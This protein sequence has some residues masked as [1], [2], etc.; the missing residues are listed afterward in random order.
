MGRESRNKKNRGRRFSPKPKIGRPDDYF[1]LGT[2]EIAR[3]GKTVVFRNNMSQ[4]QADSLQ[5][6][7]AE[8]F[9]EVV[10][11]IDNIISQIIRRVSS[12]P[13]GE[14]LKRGYWEMAYHHADI[15]G[16]ID[17]GHE[18]MVSLRMVDYLQG[19]IASVQP[20]N[21]GQGEIAD[22]DWR[23]L[24][25]LVDKLFIKLNTE[26]F[27]CQAAVRKFR[28]SG[29]T[30][31]YMDFY[32]KAQGYWC[33]VRGHRY[34]IHDVP[35]LREVLSPHD[36]ILREFYGLGAK[37]VVD[38]L[39]VIRDSLT[40]G[41]FTVLDDCAKFQ[42]DLD[43][44]LAKSLE[45]SSALAQFTSEDAIQ[46]IIDEKGWRERSDDIA[47]RLTGLDMFDLEKLTHLPKTL[48]DDLSWS[49]G[50]DKEFFG[51]GEY[52]G[53]PLRVWPV[54]KRPFI[55]L[56]NRY[57]CFDLYSLFDHA[58]R[59]IQRL[60]IKKRPQYSTTWKD[61]QQE[62]SERIPID[63]F[64]KL[65]PGVQ[66]HRQ[67]FYRWYTG[68]DAIKNWCETDA[69]LIHE[70][71]LIIMEVRGGA[72]TYTSPTTDFQSHI[73]SL[74]N[75]VLKP[76]E[77]GRR[78]MAYL[79]SGDSVKLYDGDHNE[80][81]TISRRKF[82]QVVIC[83][84]TLD[85]FTELAAKTQHLKKIGI[86]VGTYPIWSISIDDLWV[87][88]DIFTNPLV[89]LH[90]VKER[91]KAFTLESLEA[92]DELDHL[93]LYLKH[94]LYTRYV[95]E[96]HARAKGP[97]KWHG[98]RA[99]IDRYFSKRF[100]EPEQCGILQQELSPRVREVL[101]VLATSRKLGRR[102]LAAALLDCSGELRDTLGKEIDKELLQ[103]VSSR[104][105]KPFSSHGEA[106]ITLF[107][108]QRGIVDRDRQVAS[109]HARTVMLVANESDRLLLELFY[110]AG[111][112]IDIEHEFLS[113]DSI[114]GDELARIKHIA[115]LLRRQ[116]L[117]N[118]RLV[119]GG[120]GRNQACPCGS[121]KK[122]KKCCSL[123][124]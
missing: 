27:L 43:A 98:Y 4:E 56:D 85:P 31:D 68:S 9:P 52:R 60:L 26:F 79:E 32:F 15:S 44:E 33:N 25:T 3:V 34:L 48:L 123:T 55:K 122:Y 63:L 88:A 86:E 95:Q 109:D 24:R 84:I 81:D 92:E 14:L 2:L 19:I 47:G 59:I 96:S 73:Q 77:Q 118:A 116:R 111:R 87:Y 67:V 113:V 119:E 53:W 45:R 64:E 117:E 78:F 41:I 115:E 30:Q 51:D 82:E 100:I 22:E 110:E 97:I 124:V 69:L 76:A 29:L 35:I 40:R 93:G 101:E 39:E 54:F 66:I 83:A 10:R 8:R 120:I 75:L 108:W 6:K 49:P 7:L 28:E 105:A 58:Y 94:N 57:Y 90:F 12:L 21:T 102:K 42:A 1:R 80:I 38:A 71:C 72:F 107:C 91:I 103:Q 62:I 16:E 5:A 23:E 17:V 11:E 20:A 36:S 112:L 50:E 18:G 106:R 121:G 74:R 89:F 99:D 46:K 65:L 104:R 37:D 70:D 61:K 114:P 13:P